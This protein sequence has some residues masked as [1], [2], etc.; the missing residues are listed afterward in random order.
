MGG[1]KVRDEVLAEEEHEKTTSV[2]QTS[3]NRGVEKCM[4]E[5]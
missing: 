5:Q 2:I 1:W 3:R 4:I